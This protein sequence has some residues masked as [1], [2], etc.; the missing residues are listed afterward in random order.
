MTEQFE[1]AELVKIGIEDERS[2]VA[3]YSRLAEKVENSGLRGI[4]AD[5]AEQEKYHQRRFEEMLQ[6]LGGVRTPEEYP[7]QYMAYLSALTSGRAFPDPEGAERAADECESDAA[8][9]ALAGRFERDTIILMNE[10]RSL[11]PKKD[12]QIVDELIREEQNHLVTLSEARR[13]VHG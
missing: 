11:V 4:F 13:K 8:A 10:M 12:G 7:G 3:F 9:V 2:G 5:L 1:V 6:R